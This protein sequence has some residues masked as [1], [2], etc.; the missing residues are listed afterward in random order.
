MESPQMRLTGYVRYI[1]PA[2]ID[3]YWTVENL[4]RDEMSMKYGAGPGQLTV[5]D[6]L[7]YH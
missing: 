4:I 1:I 6:K 7:D 5:L 3:I 2:S